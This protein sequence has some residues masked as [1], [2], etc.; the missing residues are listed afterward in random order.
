MEPTAAELRGV[1]GQEADGD[2]LAAGGERLEGGG[3]D[4]HED[5]CLFTFFNAVL[6]RVWAEGGG[7]R[8]QLTCCAEAGGDLGQT[9]TGDL[10]GGGGG[11]RHQGILEPLGHINGQRDRRGGEEGRYH[12]RA[13][14][15]GFVRHD[16]RG[17]AGQ[18][19]RGAAGRVD[20]LLLLPAVAEPHA[21]DLLLHVELLGHQQDLL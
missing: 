11:Q 2:K 1:I 16:R 14:A 18:G 12:V 17:L 6:C 21:D 3:T 20:A 15:G 7:R 10:G 9:G 8:S 4:V 13:V 19:G 5:I